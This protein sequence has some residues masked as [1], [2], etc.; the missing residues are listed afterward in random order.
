MTK[1]L[2]E[3][4][5]IFSFFRIEL[6]FSYFIQI[7]RHYKGQHVLKALTKGNNHTIKVLLAH[8]SESYQKKE[9]DAEALI[10]VSK[11]VIYSTYWGTFQKG[12]ARSSL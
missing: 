2:N 7:L 1:C 5:H 6:S 11:T 3:I 9:L 8:E 12:F 10:I 4:L